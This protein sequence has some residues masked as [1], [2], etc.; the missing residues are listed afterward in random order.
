M[1]GIIGYIGDKPVVPVLLDGLNRLAY[2]GYDSA[3]IA[4]VKDGQMQVRRRPGK[5]R[6]LEKA[7]V[8]DP[9]EGEMGLGHCLTPD[10]LIQL[11]DGRV[12]PIAELQDE[13]EVLSLNPQTFQLEAR[14]ARVFRHRA[15]EKLI[16]LRTASTSVTCTAEHRLFVMDETGALVE[17]FA[18]DLKT[19][20]VMLLA[21][22]IPA[23]S[24]PQSITFAS[25]APRRY[26]SLSETTSLNL[27][28]AVVHSGLTKTVVAER[29]GISFSALE[30]M[31]KNDRN[32]REAYLQ[33]VCET[34]QLDFPPAEAAPIHSHHGNFV[35][36]PTTSTPELMQLI[37]YFIGDGHAHERCL[38]WKDQR[39]EVLEYYQQIIEQHFGLEGRIV[40]LPNVDAWLL[41]VNSRDMANWFRENIVRRRNELLTQIGALSNEELAGFLKGLFDAEGY[42]ASK[43]GQVA[44]CMTDIKLV[45]CLQQWL[46]RFEVITSLYIIPPKEN[47]R[48][49]KAYAGLFIS[50]GQSI[51]NFE[52]QIGFV[53]SEKIQKLQSLLERKCQDRARVSKAIP[54]TTDSLVRQLKEQN[55]PA[56]V[57]RSVGNCKYLTERQGRKVISKLDRFPASTATQQLLN[58][59]LAGDAIFQQISSVREVS[60]ASEIVYDIEVPDVENFFANGLLQHNSRWATHGRP[61]EENA[62]PHRDSSGRICV[63]HNGI[64]ENYLE[65]KRDLQ[66][67]DHQFQSETDTEV[68]AHLIAEHLR[69][70][71][72]LGLEGA[73]RAMLKQVRGIYALV[74]IS[75]DEPNKIVT[76][77]QGP[78]VVVGLG[79]DEYFVASDITAILEHTRNMFF[80]NDGEMATLTR[81]GVKVEDANGKPVNPNVQRVNWDP[82]QAEKG[83]FKQFMLKEIYEQPRAVRDTTQNRVSLD[84]GHVYL[85]EINIPAAYF[86]SFSDIKIAACGTAWHAALVAKYLIEEL[87]RVPVEV[88]YASEFRYRNPILT[89]STLMMVISQSGETA[90]TLAALR[91]AK[92]KACRSI[93]ICNVQ[94]SMMTR[95]ADGTI[96]THAGPEIGVASTK[97]F[98][99]QMVAA[100]LFALYLAQERKTLSEEQ[101]QWHVRHLS[102]LP[103]KME[104]LL[105]NPEVDYEDLSKHFVLSSDFLYLGRGIN[106]PIALEG[107]LKLKEISYI[108]A[109]GY[110]A[111]EMKHG[112]NALIDSRLPVVVI[113][114][115]DSDD[116]KSK[117]RYEK[118]LSNIQEVRAR[119]G[120]V[121]AIV[122]EGDQDTR[123]M[124]SFTIEVPPSSELLSPV[125]STIPMQ[126]LAYHVAVRRGC[127]VDQPRNLAKSVTV[128]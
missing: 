88:D 64:I 106:F 48:R 126:L 51:Q 57:I 30:H 114:T 124:A 85:D 67:K 54:V 50:S 81:E 7:L 99:S 23:P 28:Q 115:L 95:E 71:P 12:V 60:S 24:H 42:I 55:V 10:T 73:F 69:H 102:E 15:P 18:R 44:L 27:R 91:E 72:S 76:A 52:Q 112:P 100:Y 98:T 8:A 103:V 109:E 41:E 3:G 19:G 74:A 75:A 58:K 47:H 59:F 66:K 86:R 77:R 5:I 53:A 118:T 26:W 122:T 37:G 104:K 83:G 101:L 17:R 29:A 11:A 39:R 117:L 111:G 4:V 92:E 89:P 65:L 62:H 13:F 34:L 82:I 96:Y 38:R 128:E 116:E 46:L 110:A 80:L 56:S 35:H 119:D 127:D 22:R 25:A 31:L 105:N 108:H 123:D 20:D 79:E 125:L 1:C 49:K 107:A 78:P 61:S 68:V 84:T 90:D 16:E 36:L 94:G 9:I 70:D 43:A 2:R 32:A 113:N 40:R 121:V 97:A 120:I 87:A 45:R 63:V 93:A 21:K 14:T 6:E 33:G